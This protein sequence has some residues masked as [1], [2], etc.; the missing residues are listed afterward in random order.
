MRNTACEKNDKDCY[1]LYEFIKLHAREK[2][3]SAETC[4]IS[5]MPFFTPFSCHHK[6]QPL[7]ISEKHSWQPLSRR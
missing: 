5:S 7:S 3:T 1:F 2:I 4:G 6:Q